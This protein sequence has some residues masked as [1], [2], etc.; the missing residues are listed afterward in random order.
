MTEKFIVGMDPRLSINVYPR[1]DRKFERRGSLNFD[2]ARTKIFRNRPEPPRLWLLRYKIYALIGVGTGLATVLITELENALFFMK[3]SVTNNIIG[4][5]GNNLTWGFVFFLSV[6]VVLGFA[7]AVLV[8]YM[9]PSAAHSGTVEMM[10]YLNGINNNDWFGLEMFFIKATAIIMAGASGLCVG[11]TGTFPHI[12]A[13]IG[14]GAVYL[15][16]RDFDFFHVDYHKREFVSA[17]L[18]CGMAVAFGAPIGGT[19]FGYEISQPNFY[20]QYNNLW[21]TFLTC[22][23]GVIV[24]SFC[25]DLRYV[26]N[27]P[28]GWVLNSSP[29]RFQSITAPIASI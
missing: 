15:P 8:V 11:K 3:V 26:G 23:L 29:M 12:G 19:L 7:A 21:R 5:A 2:L 17:G 24:Y 28:D 4:G 9:A 14:L 25:V 6:S 1:L 13:M 10:S 20:Y 27:L 16:F 22:T 18:A